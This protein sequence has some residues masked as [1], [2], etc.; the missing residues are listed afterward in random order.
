MAL[1]PN[2]SSILV[3][4]RLRTEGGVCVEPGGGCSPGRPVEGV[5]AALH[6]VATG[7][8]LWAIRAAITMDYDFPAPAISQDGCY[9]L[10]GLAPNVRPLI[11]LV[12][13]DDGQI[14]QTIP[15]PGSS[16]AM[17]FTRGGSSVWTHAYGLTALYDV[18]PAAR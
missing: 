10:I 16:Y 17:G 8:A 13:M 15:A 6:D 7:R 14:V 11:A 9:A 5:L 3:G 4:R 18:Q 1:S 2:G 12:S